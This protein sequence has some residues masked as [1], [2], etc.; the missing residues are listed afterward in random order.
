M[1]PSL[2]Q[3]LYK[4]KFTEERRVSAIWI[5][6]SDELTLLCSQKGLMSL[7]CTALSRNFYQNKSFCRGLG[8]HA[9]ASCS[10]LVGSPTSSTIQKNLPLNPTVLVTGA[11]RGIGRAI[12]LELGKVGCRVIVNHSSA[13]HHSASAADEVCKQ[14]TNECAKRGNG[15]SAV[16][17]PADVADPQQVA[18]MFA[19]I[20]STYGPVS[21]SY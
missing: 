3:Y 17:M 6:F 7:S 19:Q 16:A 2:S 8:A 10:T 9:Q 1:S 14:I 20:R 21:R 18:Q 4:T 15:G 5:I 12:A 11:S 13:L